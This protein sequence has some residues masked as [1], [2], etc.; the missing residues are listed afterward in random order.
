MWSEER[1]VRGAS[2]GAAW[3][4]AALAVF[5][6]MLAAGLPWGRAAWGGGQ[7]NLSMGLRVASGGA[8]ALFGGAALVVA[9]R[10][11][12]RVWAPLPDRWLPAAVWVLAA[13]T[14]VGTL[15]NVASRSPLERAVM[16]PTA[17]SLAVLCTIVAVK[18][19]R[20]DTDRLPTPVDVGGQ[21]RR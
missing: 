14:G 5:E 7:A 2:L 12:H 17:F 6:A 3:L 9:R 11:G 19:R 4:F 20:D 13:Y 15:L 21:R 8:V 16:A 10:G 1:T 18:S